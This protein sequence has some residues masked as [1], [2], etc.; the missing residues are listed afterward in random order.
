MN[1]EEMQ[2]KLIFFLYKTN[3]LKVADPKSPFWY[4]SGTIGPYYVNTH[5]LFNNAK[6]AN[7]LLEVINDNKNDILKCPLEVAKVIKEAYDKNG[8]FKETIDILI[9]YIRA[10]I[11]L[12]SVDYVSGG[13]RRDWFFSYLVS[14]KL[15]I[16]HLWIY[17]DL[18]IVK[19][20]GE[21]TETIDDLTDKN[22]LHIADLV[23]VASSYIR[24]WIPA[25]EDR[26]GKMVYSVNILDRNQGGKK[27]IEDNGPETHLLI[28]MNDQFLKD[29]LDNGYLSEGQYNVL[30]KYIKNPDEVM[31]QFIKDNPAF[32]ENALNSDDL[33]TRERAKLCID[34]KIYE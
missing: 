32:L 34:S 10:N 2:N 24:S 17:K 15:D 27:I 22:V 31:K 23:T 25:I 13:E 18:S 16:P 14:E 19:H 26:G 5:F 7:M 28:S 9:D 20:L 4:T 30:I 3:A 21:E 33:K 12:D 6:D 11:D 29:S 1:K 8:I